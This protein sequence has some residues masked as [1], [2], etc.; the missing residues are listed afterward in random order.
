L[1]EHEEEPEMGNCFIYASVG[2][3]DN[4]CNIVDEGERIIVKIYILFLVSNVQAFN[5]AI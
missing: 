5:S 1:T 4:E 2:K 3:I